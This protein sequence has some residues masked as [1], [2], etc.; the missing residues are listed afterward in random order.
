LVRKPEDESL[1]ITDYLDA[2]PSARDQW[3]PQT[4]GSMFLLILL[5]IIRLSGDDF[6]LFA[7][8]VAGAPGKR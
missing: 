3:F 5:H 4:Y 8:G 1:G 2:G 7:R 6:G